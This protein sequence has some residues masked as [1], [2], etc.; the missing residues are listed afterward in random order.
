[1]RGEELERFHAGDADLFRSLIEHESPR[2]LGYAMRLTR[3]SVA[4]HE[5]VHDTWVRAF[6]KRRT[7]T[8][9]GLL[10]GWLLAICRSLHFA[11]HR[12]RKRFDERILPQFARERQDEVSDGSERLALQRSLADAIGRLPHQQRDVVLCRVVEDLSVRETA[13]RLGIAEGTVKAALHQALRKL[14]TLLHEWSR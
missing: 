7:Y 5:L 12:R 13:R 14:R 2:L 1:M 10:L 3:G 11:E 9:D 6:E 8:G 4:A